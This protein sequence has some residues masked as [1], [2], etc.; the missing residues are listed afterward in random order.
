MKTARARWAAVV[1]ALSIAGIAGA[2]RADD[3]RAVD[4]ARKSFEA[5]MEQYRSG[6]LE[7]ARISLAQSY[8]AWPSVETLRNLAIAEVNTNHIVEALRHF[9]LYARDRN[10]D[11]TFVKTKLPGY[12][13]RCQQRVGHLRI[14]A[15]PDAD[16]T[17]DGHRVESLG[18]ATDV[19]PGVHTVALN[20][21][22][23]VDARSAR[24]VATKTTEVDFVAPASTAG[25]T[26]AGAAE[27]PGVPALQPSPMAPGAPSAAEGAAPEEH[28]FMTRNVVVVALSALALGSAGVGVG[29]GV[30]A[31]GNRSA[32]EGL[33]AGRNPSTC[34]MP[35]DVAYCSSLQSAL[36]V[37]RSNATASNVAFGVAGVLAVGAAVAMFAWPK[38][39]ARAARTFWIAPS[40][41]GHS[42]VVLAG[43]AF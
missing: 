29:F 6:D 12:L 13:E 43:A 33:T 32:V 20:T 5:G 31:N 17:I 25:G 37:Q 26:L 41:V 23:K 7:G 22:G 34:A 39:E 27:S 4:I 16:V 10:A 1:A 11:P 19:L 38:G 30:A 28:S 21:Q 3:G 14:K 24:V 2:A 9:R 35:T 18:E 36:S 15:A 40:M 42:G 8:A